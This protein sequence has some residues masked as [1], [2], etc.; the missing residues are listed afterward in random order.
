MAASPERRREA[1]VVGRGEAERVDE[2]RSHFARASSGGSPRSRARAAGRPRRTPRAPSPSARGARG[3]RGATARGAGP[4][5]RRPR[6]P[7]P[8]RPRR[9][10]PGTSRAPAWHAA[11]VVVRDPRDVEVPF[12]AMP[13]HTGS[14]R[15]HL[16][17]LERRRRADRARTRRA[18]T[19]VADGVEQPEP[20]L[21]HVG[22]EADLEHRARAE[23]ERALAY[24][25]SD[26]ALRAALPSA[27]RT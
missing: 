22:L 17:H 4:S 11:Q 9:G 16:E 20:E 1:V 10:S 21:E 15:V 23:A 12:I 7:S 26:H 6:G 3:S 18:R 14:A 27:R 19:P 24:L 5:A 13:A 8:G 2:A 25:A